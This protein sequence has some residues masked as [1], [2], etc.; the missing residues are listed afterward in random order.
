MRKRGNW[1]HRGRVLSSW[2]K[3]GEWRHGK[4]FR[5]VEMDMDGWRKEGE[6]RDG[7]LYNG[8]ET[9]KHWRKEYRNGKEVE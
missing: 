9:R 6:W 4:L 5:G 7:E 1:S 3:E 8:V 2:R